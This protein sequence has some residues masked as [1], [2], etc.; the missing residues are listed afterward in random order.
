M[1]HFG[2][3]AGHGR[4]AVTDRALTAP[5]ETQISYRPRASGSPAVLPLWCHSL[6]SDPGKRWEPTA[7]SLTS[8]IRLI[9]VAGLRD[10]QPAKA[11]ASRLAI[12]RAGM[13]VGCHKR[14]AADSQHVLS[15]SYCYTAV[16][17]T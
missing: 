10:F 1:D 15:N 7:R 11:R 3:C 17:Y 16:L 14:R 4:A 6:L 12:S 9:T 8:G 2:A 13:A 5:T